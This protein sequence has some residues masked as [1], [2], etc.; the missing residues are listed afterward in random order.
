MRRA[1]LSAFQFAKKAVDQLPRSGKIECFRREASMR[2]ISISIACSFAFVMSTA[3]AQQPTG[4]SDEKIGHP[5]PLPGPPPV[6]DPSARQPSS[7]KPAS[8]GYTGAYQPAGTAASPYYSGPLPQISTGPGLSVAGPNGESRTVKAV[9]CSLAARETD[10]STTCVG[11]PDPNDQ[12]PRKG[13][14]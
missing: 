4:A 1:S 13:R 8:S 3:L 14:R 12:R 11:I 7:E 6:S 5:P 9:P 2:L 10:G